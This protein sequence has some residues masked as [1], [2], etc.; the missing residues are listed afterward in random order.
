MRART[1]Y[2]A[3]SLTGH[4]CNEG[5]TRRLCHIPQQ[6][7]PQEIER[8][9]LKIMLCSG[10]AARRGS[11]SQW[12]RG[13][14]TLSRRC[15]RTLHVCPKNQDPRNYKISTGAALTVPKHQLRRGRTAALLRSTFPEASAWDWGL[16]REA[17][18]LL[19]LRHPPLQREPEKGSSMDV[20]GKMS[21]RATKR[22]LALTTARCP[23][24]R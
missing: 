24:F 7:G 4:S 16:Y 5:R 14:S 13:P 9:A 23:A 3:R 21:E 1:Q 18:F 6:N 8:K 2:A 12:S 19:I 20:E 10:A 17:K 15:A 11:I 22:L